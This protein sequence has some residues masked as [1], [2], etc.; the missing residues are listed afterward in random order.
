VAAQEIAGSQLNVYEGAARGLFF[1]HKD[2][3]NRD[4]LAFV[5]R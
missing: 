3:L 5:R 2:R 1:I 4:L